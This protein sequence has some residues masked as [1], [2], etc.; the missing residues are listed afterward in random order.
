MAEKHDILNLED[1]KLLVDSFYSKA[2]ENELLGPI[3]NEK[4]GDHWPEH[5]EKMVRFWQTLLLGEHTYSGNPLLHHL[6]LPIS[7]DHFSEWLRMFHETID[8][9]FVGEK[10][11]EAHLRAAKI[12]LVMQTKLSQFNAGQ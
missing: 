8:T 1:V 10:A 7:A 4:I 3:F 2:R 6:H 5:L 9:F 12:S 11:Q